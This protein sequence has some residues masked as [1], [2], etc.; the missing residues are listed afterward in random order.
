VKLERNL[1][2]PVHLVPRLFQ[3]EFGRAALEQVCRQLSSLV[4]SA[5]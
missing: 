4:G 1:G 2:V 3:R 5:G